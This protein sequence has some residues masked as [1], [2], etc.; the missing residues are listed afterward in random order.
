MMR[1][2]WPL[3]WKLVC[4]WLC[5][6][7]GHSC[8][9]ALLA[10]DSFPNS[11]ATQYLPMNSPNC[12]SLVR[13][14]FCSLQFPNSEVWTRKS[15]TGSSSQKGIRLEV[16]DWGNCLRE[17]LMTVNH[18]FRIQRQESGSPLFIA[19]KHLTDRLWSFVWSAHE[20]QSFKIP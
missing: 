11:W 3:R 19:A 2:A 14:C 5:L 17:E 18:H 12:E 20:K 4:S 15:T 13:I 1:P 6:H 7:P 16:W 10:P 8:C 9:L